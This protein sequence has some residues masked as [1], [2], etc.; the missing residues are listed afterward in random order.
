MRRRI[1]IAVPFL[2]DA[3]AHQ[4]AASRFLYA[5]IVTSERYRLMTRR[6]GLND[7]NENED[8]DEDRGCSAV[9]SGM[10]LATRLTVIINYQ[11]G[12]RA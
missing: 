4:R 7:D 9:E 6:K 11:F 5:P 12:C 1:V 8:N 2:Y 3:P 10:L